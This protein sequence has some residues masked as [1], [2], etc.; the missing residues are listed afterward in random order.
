MTQ[1]SAESYSPV[2]P[3]RNFQ[4]RST[5][6]SARTLA[7]TREVLACVSH[8][9]LTPAVFERAHQAFVSARADV[10]AA[11]TAQVQARFLAGIAR[12][13]FADVTAEAAD[14]MAS[15]VGAPPLAPAD[16]TQWF[17]QLAE[18]AMQ[19][20]H[21]SVAAFQ[22]EVAQSAGSSTGTEGT[23]RRAR[24]GAAAIQADGA[25]RLSRVVALYLEFLDGM[26]DVTAACEEDYLRHVF[27]LAH[28]TTSAPGVKFDGTLG[29]EAETSV[30]I[31]NT[32]GAR[33]TIRCAVGEVRRA[34]GIG[35][36]FAPPV[37]VSPAQVALEPGEDTRVRVA[38]SLDPSAFET[39]AVYVGDLHIHRDG[40]P[41]LHVPMRVTAGRAKA[42]G[43]DGRA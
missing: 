35:P 27:A 33:T 17:A 2:D 41:T 7:R 9:L 42:E 29:D 3:Y 21:A 23:Q 38:L 37:V 26:S 40:H 25:E 18:R 39:G 36:A 24:R 8:G 15:V 14:V 4:S 1:A 16:S 6:R 43:H 31:E 22:A 28:G 5:A 12:L 34:D 10:Y 13:G 20:R 11:Q 30:S 32:T 19:L